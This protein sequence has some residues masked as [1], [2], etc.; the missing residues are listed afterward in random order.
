MDESELRFNATENFDADRPWE[1]FRQK[2]PP[3]RR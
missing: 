1:N 3:D 2:L